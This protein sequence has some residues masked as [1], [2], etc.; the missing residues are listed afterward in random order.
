MNIYFLFYPFIGIF[1][2][3]AS[4]LLGIGG[5]LIVVPA[6]AFV[7]TLASVPPFEIMHLA[8]G[9]SLAVMIVTAISGMIAHHRLKNILW[10]IFFRLLPSI[11]IGVI[12]G[13]I[14]AGSLN[15]R[16]LEIIFGVFLLF[17]SITMFSLAQPKLTRCLPRW[18]LLSLMGF[19][20]GG[21]SGLLGVGGGAVTIPLLTYC[22]VSMRNISGISIAC[23]LPISIV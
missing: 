2:G 4:G 23:A 8:A 12:V 1:A 20:I 9:T 22:N 3:L 6:L 11:L 7:F 21:N 15:T 16:W 13:A 14:F 19:V 18:P 17:I 10:P 5:G